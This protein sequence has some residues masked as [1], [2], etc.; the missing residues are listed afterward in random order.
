MELL[1]SRGVREVTVLGQTVD[2]YGHDLPDTNGGRPDLATLLTRLNDVD[3]LD[4]I[5]FLTSHPQ[6]YEPQHHRSRWP[7]CPRCA[8]TST[9]R[10]R[11]GMTRCW[12][13]C[14]ATTPAPI[15]SGWWSRIRDTVPGASLST[16]II[17]GFPGETETQ[18]QRTLELV[19][20]LRMDKVHCAAYSTRP[21]TIADR[22]MEDDILQEEKVS[23]RERVDALQQSILTEINA[24]LV[25]R[26]VR[27]TGR[28]E[29]QGQV[30]G[31]H[32]FQQAGVLPHHRGRRRPAGRDGQRDD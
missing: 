32:P 26:R 9:C 13:G 12:P 24:E 29:E 23:R 19:E 30:A 16:D 17:V 4:R 15:T 1:V 11:P 20:Q 8:S 7:S 28:G 31:P 22:T 10:Y 3:G 25:G 5:R 2:A 21:G 27:G 14:A 6:L 18:F